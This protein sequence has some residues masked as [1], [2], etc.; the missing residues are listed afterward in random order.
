MRILTKLYLL[1][2]RFYR[3]FISPAICPQCIYQ[4][5][6]SLFFIQSVEKFG[7]VKGTISG[8]ARILRCSRFF[9]GGN[10]PV[11]E[12]WSLK[13]IKQCYTIFRRHIR[14]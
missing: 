7:I 11:P 9:L 1:P 6:C 2:V 13:Q 14:F 3:R 5:S 4:P 12:S 10:D 8:I